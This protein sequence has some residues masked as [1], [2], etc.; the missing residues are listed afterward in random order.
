MLLIS[1]RVS[2]HEEIDIDWLKRSS[3][4]KWTWFLVYIYIY[5]VS[6]SQNGMNSLF[7]HE[8]VS[9][10]FN[11]L[12]VTHTNPIFLSG[13]CRPVKNRLEGVFILYSKMLSL[14]S[15]QQQLRWSKLKSCGF[16]KT[17]KYTQK[18]KCN[19]KGNKM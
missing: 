17:L 11:P 13:K 7:P 1:D 2:Y 5:T 18:L 15:L 16:R 14:S 19:A 4:A 12:W 10:T 8:N 9:T 3:D 6:T